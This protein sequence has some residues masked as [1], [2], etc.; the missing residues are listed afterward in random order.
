MYICCVI[1]E[2]GEVKNTFGRFI[3]KQL[4]RVKTIN[5]NRI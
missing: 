5:I 1:G 2:K 3:I 4:K